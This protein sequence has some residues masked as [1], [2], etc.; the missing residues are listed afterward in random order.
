M[1]IGF[2]IIPIV[3]FIL[4]FSIFDQKHQ[5]HND[6]HKYHYVAKLI[7]GN[8]TKLHKDMNTTI[9]AASGNTECDITNQPIKTIIVKDKK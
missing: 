4:M 5:D 3:L 7:D 6:N 1:A 8:V 9:A 2:V